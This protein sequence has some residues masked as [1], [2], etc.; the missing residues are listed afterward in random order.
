MPHSQGFLWEILLWIFLE[1]FLILEGTLIVQNMV[2]GI[3]VAEWIRAEQQEK[4]DARWEVPT[5]S[6]DA[7]QYKKQFSIPTAGKKKDPDAGDAETPVGYQW[8]WGGERIS[9]HT[10]HL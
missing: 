5:C 7:G 4:S 6:S 10:A 3:H 1:L 8:L 2:L 9:S